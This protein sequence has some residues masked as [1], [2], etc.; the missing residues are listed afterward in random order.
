M[1]ITK[2]FAYIVP[3]DGGKSVAQRFDIPRGTTSLALGATIHLPESR[4]H[5]G[6]IALAGIRSGD[7][8]GKRDLL[9]ELTVGRKDQWRLAG[10]DAKPEQAG[11][12]NPIEWG[13][14]VW[15]ELVWSS[16]TGRVT[17]GVDGRP[18]VDIGASYDLRDGGV[19]F[20]GMDVRDPSKREYVPMY[21]MTMEGAVTFTH[22]E[23]APPVDPPTELARIATDLQRLVTRIIAEDKRLRS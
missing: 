8:E 19:I 4:P 18:S 12:K 2:D 16:L 20:I 15:I 21:G 9:C 23:V 13:D 22:G 11:S 3:E 6:I 14:S 7:R 5:G 17:L 10:D 1:M